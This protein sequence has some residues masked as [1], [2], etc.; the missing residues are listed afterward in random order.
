M[1]HA[2][3]R[4]LL[5]AHSF[6]QAP[7]SLSPKYII[8]TPHCEGTSLVQPSVFACTNMEALALFVRTPLLK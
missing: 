1:Y 6:K 2:S 5:Q 3:Q 8:L 7:S 4:Q